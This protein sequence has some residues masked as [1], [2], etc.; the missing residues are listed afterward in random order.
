MENNGKK[1]DAYRS[2]GIIDVGAL[3]DLSDGGDAIADGNGR[4]QRGDVSRGECAVGV[5]D[6]SAIEGHNE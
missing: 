1:S 2:N 5:E 6:G 3:E 4:V